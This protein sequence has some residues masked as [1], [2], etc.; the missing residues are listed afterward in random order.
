MPTQGPISWLDGEGWLV[1][2]GG[3]DWATGETE[4]VDM[5]LLS[6][7]NLDRPMVVLLSEG[8][9][10]RADTLLDYFTELGGPGGEA[11]SIEGITRDQLHTPRFLTLIAEAGILCLGGEN[12]IP[13]V[14][15][16]YNNPVLRQIVQGYTTLQALTVIGVGGG[17][18]ALAKWAFGPAPNYLRAMGLGWLSN[19][20]VVPHF[21]RTEDSPIL[22]Q[23]PRIAP[24]VLGL[25]IP[26]GCA[27]ALGPLGQVETWGTGNVTAVI[28][29]DA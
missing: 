2:A 7:A 11:F 1:L 3:G 26:N 18:A 28:N 5:R 12:P 25:G 29:A 4:Q 19:A 15:N 17:A 21:T 8:S 24:D 20:V 14:Q 22:K 27:L 16:I 9:R 23:L 10:N 6:I 13:L